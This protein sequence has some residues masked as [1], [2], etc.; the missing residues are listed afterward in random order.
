MFVEILVSFSDSIRTQSQKA[1]CE[2]RTRLV[3]N[4]H[5][6]RTI[7]MFGTGICSMKGICFFGKKVDA[8][9]SGCSSP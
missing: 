5:L 4:I 9:H 6:C 3:Q 7:L 1:K 2:S 8:S